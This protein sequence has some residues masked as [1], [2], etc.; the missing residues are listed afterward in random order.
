[1]ILIHLLVIGSLAY[2]D[3]MTINLHLMELEDFFPIAT[4][5]QHPMAL[6][7]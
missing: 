1:V 5:W 2:F 3:N 4:C 7:T 6:E